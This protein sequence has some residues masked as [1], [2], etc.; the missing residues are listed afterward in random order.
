MRIAGSGNRTPYY[1]RPTQEGLLKHYLAI[2]DSVDIPMIVYNIPGRTAGK[3]ELD[4]MIKLADHDNIIGLKDATGNL[5][6]ASLLLAARPDFQLF[7]GDDLLT[8]PII[9]IGGSGVVSVAANLVPDK[10]AELTNLALAGDFQNANLK[11]GMIAN[12]LQSMT[13]EVNPIPIKTALAKVGLISDEFRL[14]LSPMAT[15]NRT[16]LFDAMRQLSLIK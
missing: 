1:N 7:A 14:P 5:A 16:L 13:L 15:S 12:L 11:L 2:A 10:M 3:I 4:T 9:A 8:I 6:E